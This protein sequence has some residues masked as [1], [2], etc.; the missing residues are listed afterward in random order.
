[1][2]MSGRQYYDNM[3]INKVRMTFEDWALTITEKT[4][5][6]TASVMTGDSKNVQ[7]KNARYF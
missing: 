4:G 3:P 5:R 1:M 2:N 6:W 7:C